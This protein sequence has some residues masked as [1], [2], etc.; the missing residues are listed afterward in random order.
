MS[1]ETYETP[2]EDAGIHDERQTGSDGMK[3][4]A[5][6]SYHLGAFAI[7]RSR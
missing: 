6:P 1:L 3:T 2:E 4:L 7:H 5:K